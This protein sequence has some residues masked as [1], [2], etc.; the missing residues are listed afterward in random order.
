MAISLG[1]GAHL[2]PHSHPMGPHPSHHGTPPNPSM[3]T[4]QVA[5]ATE[6][7]RHWLL[8]LG[9]GSDVQCLHPWNHA[10]LWMTTDGFE[11]MRKHHIER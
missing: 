9:W 1:A 7:G 3:M 10:P 6:E 8:I 11:A 2:G 5:D 4:W